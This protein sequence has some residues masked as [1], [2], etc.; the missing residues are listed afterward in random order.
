ME[1]GPPPPQAAPSLPKVTALDMQ[2]AVHRARLLFEEQSTPPAQ[3]ECAEVIE[4]LL[5]QRFEGEVVECNA[6]FVVVR[7]DMGNQQFERRFSRTQ[8]PTLQQ[9]DVVELLSTLFLKPPTKPLT[10]AQVDAWEKRNINWAA[11]QAKTKR[12]PSLLDDEHEEKP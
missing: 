1:E 3:T 6:D 11:A 8:L 2:S 7:F 4:P 9:G 10:D 12:A 5:A